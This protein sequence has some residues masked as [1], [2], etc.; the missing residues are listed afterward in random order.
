MKKVRF[1]LSFKQFLCSGFIIA[2]FI[3][4]G[5]SKKGIEPDS[6][7]LSRTV[8]KADP[9]RIHSAMQ[10]FGENYLRIKSDIEWVPVWED[11]FTEELGNYQTVEVPLSFKT[12]RLY[13]L[14]ENRQAFK[15]T[16]D[17]KYIANLTRFIVEINTLRD[18]VR[19]F[20]MTI[21]PSKSYIES[22]RLME[23]N[24]SYCFRDTLFSGLVI[25][26]NMNGLTLC[27]WKYERGKAVQ[28][29]KPTGNSIIATKS[30]WY[31][32]TTTTIEWTEW[33]YNNSDRKDISGLSISESTE[34]WEVYTGTQ[35]MINWIDRGSGGGGS[36]SLAEGEWWENGHNAI[37]DAALSRFIN[38]NKLGQVKQ[39]SK[40][41]DKEPYQELKYSYMHAM[42][43][44]GQTYE[45]GVRIMRVY[46]REYVQ[47]FLNNS[48]YI[49][50]NFI[51][52]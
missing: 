2:T 38:S 19:G 10:W 31:C 4:T 9:Q 15:Q 6:D 32:E 12:E 44:P 40:N 28:F 34:C 39:G 24:N 22:S 26:R 23:D 13:A 47:K 29:L 43:Q 36:E 16:G 48:D 51:R 35:E 46:F 17:F 42:L 52:Q 37:M 14:Q 41:A 18:T 3:T 45:Q 27:V 49:P 1:L 21:V 20:F 7:L 33:T 30:D 50:K 25:Y 8:R 5:C 11:A